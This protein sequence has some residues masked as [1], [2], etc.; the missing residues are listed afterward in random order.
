[1]IIYN[2]QLV[3]DHSTRKLVKD[4]FLIVQKLNKEKIGKMESHNNKITGEGGGEET[5][6]DL[7]KH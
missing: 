6:T 4:I 5:T 2:V 3:V 7:L 1:M